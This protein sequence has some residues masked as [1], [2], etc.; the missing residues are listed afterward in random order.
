MDSIRITVDDLGVKARLKS[1]PKLIDKISLLVT[2]RIAQYGHQ[3]ILANMPEDTG[4][5]KQSMGYLVTRNSP[6]WRQTSILQTSSPH[7]DK[8]WGSHGW[9][10]LPWYMFDSP[11]ALTQK[12]R[13]GNIAA[14]QGTAD[15]L[16]KKFEGDMTIQVRKQLINK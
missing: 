11:R 14:V 6:G 12:W 15:M 8:K 9:F 5:S 1:M 16:R 4:A 3:Y 2:Y 10:N 13:S 7:P